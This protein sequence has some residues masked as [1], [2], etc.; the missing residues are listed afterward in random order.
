LQAVEFRAD[1]RMRFEV[2]Y[3]PLPYFII[4]PVWLAIIVLSGGLALI[5]VTRRI[6]AYVAVCSTTGL[7]ASIV[8]STLGLILVAKLPW[9]AG[10]SYVGGAALIISYI[11]GIALGGLLGIIVG[12]WGLYKLTSRRPHSRML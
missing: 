9:P 8:L 12:F 5:P 1:T 6:A 10:G 4:I 3:G 11:G 2:S 7:I